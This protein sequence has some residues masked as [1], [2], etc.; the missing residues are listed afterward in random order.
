MD[1]KAIGLSKTGLRPSFT[2]FLQEIHAKKWENTS[3]PPTPFRITQACGVSI[4]NMLGIERTLFLAIQDTRVVLCPTLQSKVIPI[5]VFE[6]RVFQRRND[7]W[8]WI[9]LDQNLVVRVCG[10]RGSSLIY[11]KRFQASL[12]GSQ[13]VLG[14]LLFGV[15]EFLEGLFLVKIRLWPWIS[16]EPLIGAQPDKNS[17]EASSLGSRNNTTLPDFWAIPEEL[18]GRECSSVGLI[19]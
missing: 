18:H 8:T 7:F 5:P 19:F 3:S 2:H 9:T 14:G 12:F 17:D 11:I 10:Q 1:V 16:R 15:A 4:H 13:I 6:Y